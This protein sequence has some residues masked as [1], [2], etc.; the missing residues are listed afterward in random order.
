MQ[1]CR[2]K[3]VD[4]EAPCSFVKAK[5]AH[6]KLHAALQSTKSR[7][8]SSMQFCRGEK[9]ELEARIRL[10]QAK[11]QSAAVSGGYAFMLLCNLTF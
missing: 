7:V 8:G 1:L 10:A 4:L 5:K 2:G 9:V 3:K 11:K 6:R